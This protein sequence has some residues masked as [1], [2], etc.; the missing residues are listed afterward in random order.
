MEIRRPGGL[1]ASDLTHSVIGGFYAVHHALGFG[2]LEHVYAA[3]LELELVNRGHRVVREFSVPVRYHG[4]AVAYQRLDF[5]VDEK[6]VIEIKA[7]EK[8]PPNALRQTYNYLRATNLE[9]GLLLHF[10]WQPKFYR[11]VCYNSQKVRPST[12][13]TPSTP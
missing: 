12:P 6:L 7:T 11:V 13:Q 1:I 3:T 5:V 9:V 2:F 8:L 10:G 4:I